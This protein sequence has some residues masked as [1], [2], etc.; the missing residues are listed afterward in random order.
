MKSNGV[1]GDSI[2][3][4]AEATVGECRGVIDKAKGKV[5]L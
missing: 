5:N 2:N 3:T 1:Y 4:L